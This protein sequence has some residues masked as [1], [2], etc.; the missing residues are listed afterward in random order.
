MASDLG[1]THTIDASLSDPVATIIGLGGAHQAIVAATGKEA[2]DQALASLRPGGTLILLA[3]SG[4]GSLCLPI[5]ETV[6]NA[7]TVRGSI[8]GSRVDLARTFALHAAGRTRVVH[9]ARSLTRVNEAMA[10]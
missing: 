4:D 7:I 2:A 9:Q 8:G 10:E 1:A 6:H 5:S 3:I